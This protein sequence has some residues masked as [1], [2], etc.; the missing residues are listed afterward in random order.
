M[1]NQ[2][3]PISQSASGGAGCSQKDDLPGPPGA[4]RRHSVAGQG[5]QPPHS[6]ITSHAATRLAACAAI[7]CAENEDEI[8]RIIAMATL[9]TP[10]SEREVLAEVLTDAVREWRE[11]HP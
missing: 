2:R 4:Q 5:H 10:P 9:K 8:H 7:V 6:S 1:S 3:G 11:A